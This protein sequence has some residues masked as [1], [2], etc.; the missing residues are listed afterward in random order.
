MAATLE[1]NTNAY[2]VFGIL[3]TIALASGGGNLNWHFQSA[4]V[5]KN[6]KEVAVQDSDGDTV[7][8][9]Y[10]DPDGEITLNADVIITGADASGAATANGLPTPG[11][12]YTITAASQPAIAGAWTL[13]DA[14]ATL[15]N[16]G[17]QSW[18]LVFRRTLS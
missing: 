3:A 8:R 6:A 17:V 7:A 1:Y 9:A 15:N 5:S 13:R 4:Q 2:P 10:F 18:S 14:T 12:K 16:A 11:T